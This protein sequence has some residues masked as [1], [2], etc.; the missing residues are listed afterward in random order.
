MYM[1]FLHQYLAKK[2]TYS[3]LGLQAEGQAFAIRASEQHFRSESRECLFIE[4]GS[5]R[6]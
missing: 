3:F 2:S 1:I 6:A 4:S 5:G